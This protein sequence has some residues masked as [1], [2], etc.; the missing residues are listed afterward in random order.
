M[1]ADT[2]KAGRYYIL[3][4]TVL[5]PPLVKGRYSRPHRRRARPALADLK[6]V[7]EKALVADANVGLFIDGPENA[8]EHTIALVAALAAPSVNVCENMK[9]IAVILS[10]KYLLKHFCNLAA[11]QA[12][13][14]F[15]HKILAMSNF[16]A[17]PPDGLRLRSLRIKNRA[18][19]RQKQGVHAVVV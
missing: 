1:P 16:L 8:H 17:G 9:L 5:L 3:G 13:H 12:L 7:A 4:L 10:H 15:V 19:N 14:K 11:P 2:Y 6:G 18:V